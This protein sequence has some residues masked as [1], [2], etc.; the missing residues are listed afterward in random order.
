MNQAVAH[1]RGPRTFQ[2]RPDENGTFSP[3]PESLKLLRFTGCIIESTVNG[4]KI[5]RV[6]IHAGNLDPMRKKDGA[7][8]AC[9]IYGFTSAEDAALCTSQK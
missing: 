5:K 2:T 1:I 4:K 9:A 3:T 7:E 6:C 8:I